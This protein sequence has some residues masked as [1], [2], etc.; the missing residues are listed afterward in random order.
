MEQS[1]VICSSDIKKQNID[2]KE[3]VFTTCDE[4]NIPTTVLGLLQ[5]NGNNKRKSVTR[6]RTFESSKETS[7]QKQFKTKVRELNTDELR[8]LL[9][10]V[11]TV[12]G[13]LQDTLTQNNV[14]LERQLKVCHYGR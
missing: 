1:L 11:V 5:N 12:N 4:N 10:D 14:Q 3:E 2:N 8:Q 13:D 7:F 9:C 6:C